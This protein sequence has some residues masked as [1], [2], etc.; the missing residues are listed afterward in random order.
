MGGHELLLELFRGH[1]CS[2]ASLAK[3]SATPSERVGP[4]STAFT[5]T[6]VPATDSARPREIASC[7]VLV[8]P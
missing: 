1:A 8:V 7:A 4:G 5:V 6:P 3:N 2:F